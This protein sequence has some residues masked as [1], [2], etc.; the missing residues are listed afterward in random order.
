MNIKGL[1]NLILNDIYN[2]LNKCNIE[3]NEDGQKITMRCPIH[4]GDKRTACTIYKDTGK[5]YCWTHNCHVEHQSNLFAFF[6]AIFKFNTSQTIS[7]FTKY[8][9]N[10]QIEFDYNKD[11]LSFVKEVEIIEKRLEKTGISRDNVIRSL[12]IPSRYFLGRGFSS[13][14]LVKY[15][16]GECYERGKSMFNRAVVPVY[17]IDR[18]LMTGCVGRRLTED[19]NYPKWKNSDGFKRGDNLYNIW[20]AKA[21]ITKTNTVIICEGQ[22]DVW[23]LEEAGIHNS[24]GIFGSAI[25]DNQYFILEKLP[26]FNMIILTDSDEAGMKAKETIK[27]QCRRLYNVIVPE[28]PKH[29][30]GDMSIDEVKRLICP[31][32]ERL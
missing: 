22:G 18:K 19:E 11:I 5:W 13:E 15:D 8:F 24:V 20:F 16:V 12:K 10:P 6:K 31:L 14:L 4:Q 27:H 32:M 1:N 21:E 29:D 2:L 28:L 9:G 23:R 25:T 30:I 26:I 17:D 7:W 3:Y